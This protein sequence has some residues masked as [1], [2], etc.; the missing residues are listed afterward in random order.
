MGWGTALSALAGSL[1][2]AE[3]VQDK[4]LEYEFEFFKAERMVSYHISFGSKILGII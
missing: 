3:V 1:N 2:Q 4:C